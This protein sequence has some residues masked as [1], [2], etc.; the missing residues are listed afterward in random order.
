MTDGKQ[1]NGPGNL[2]PAKGSPA[3]P[4]GLWLTTIGASGIISLYVLGLAWL[5]LKN[6][7]ADP[8]DRAARTVALELADMSVESSQ[9]GALA[10]KD[11]S[12]EA[13]V[14]KECR[15]F[16]TVQALLAVSLTLAEKYR[17]AEL[18][19]E[20]QADL[21]SLKALRTELA[22]QLYQSVKPGGAIY[23]S[24]KKMLS[25]R[26][27]SREKLRGLAITLG[28]LKS[29]PAETKLEGNRQQNLLA[30]PIVS[31]SIVFDQQARL[32]RVEKVSDFEPATDNKL[33]SALLIEADYEV[34]L[35]GGNKQPLRRR[36]C[37][38]IGSTSPQT[39]QSNRANSGLCLAVSFPHGNPGFESLDSL[40]KRDNWLSSGEWQECAG[41]T[42]PGG[43]RLA[44]T[45]SPIRRPS[46]P[47]DALSICIY[48]F[49]RALR[50]PTTYEN[51]E[52]LLQEKWQAPKE[53]L[54]A[55]TI[56]PYSEEIF[57]QDESLDLSEDPTNTRLFAELEE[58]DARV[59]SCLVLGTEARKF[60]YLYK[61]GAREAGQKA[62]ADCFAGQPAHFPS[63]AL[64]LVVDDKGNI[65]LPGRDFDRALV[66]SLMTAIYNTNLAACDTIATASLVEANAGTALRQGREHLY[67]DSVDLSSLKERQGKVASETEAK[68]LNEEIRERENRVAYQ[69]EREKTLSKTISKAQS[70]RANALSVSAKS[71]ALGAHLFNLAAK[72]INRLDDKEPAFLLGKRFVFKPLVKS[73]S[74]DDLI[75][76]SDKS[77]PWLAKK[78][79]VF[80]SV[81]SFY[82]RPET[83]IMVE[84]KSLSDLKAQ[85]AF[86]NPA[87]PYTVVF[88]S[89]SLD[90]KS[91]LPPLTFAQYPFI[92]L[93][94]PEHQIVYYCQD[95]LSTGSQNQVIWS[96]LLR[97][98][99]AK[100]EQSQTSTFGN[101]ATGWCKQAA[102]LPENMFDN[103]DCPPLAAE[104]Q[105]RA[106]LMPID[107]EM[108]KVL[109]GATLTD[110]KTG[111]RAQ[112]VPP[113]GVELM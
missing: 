31:S 88:S 32:T 16:N 51:L 72:G 71:F 76:E 47:G 18:A 84:G 49:L 95:A 78:L 22:S 2:E 5:N 69:Q 106:P 50:T 102:N 15:S 74:E 100:R 40:L 20:A 4:L 104:W 101:S 29:T 30:P 43:G 21:K 65:N 46:S 93:S 66:L 37:Q 39:G 99:V 55:K 38:A 8:L 60:A 24:T 103:I 77:S 35:R 82:N 90:G 17:L 112:Q 41:G 28:T 81:K 27:R 113:A 13:S 45:V 92:N 91:K 48:H 7:D 58:S 96:S 52:R 54:S 3:S 108:Q 57:G 87:R 10:L 63:A 59:N 109:K 85:A 75:D 68:S 33:P 11:G 1:P 83:K 111:Q 14:N 19:G 64:P 25:A 73:L 56:K 98:F 107:G 79:N 42:I 44:P 34:L 86:T 12:I 89:L 53:N 36:I 62:L 110:P 6:V 97:D 70:A 26:A 105:L 61:G 80:G 94:L 67:I 9:F 23:Q